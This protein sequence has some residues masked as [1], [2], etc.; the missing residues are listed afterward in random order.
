M[1]SIQSHTAE[2]VNVRKRQQTKETPFS[3]S[4]S[5]ASQQTSQ[6]PQK[7][8]FGVSSMKFPSSLLRNTLNAQTFFLPPAPMFYTLVF[9]VGFTEGCHD[10]H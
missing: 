10:F 8:F 1:C 3:L 4:P 2:E 9:L 6:L 5:V 7:P